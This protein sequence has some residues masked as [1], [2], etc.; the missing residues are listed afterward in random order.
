MTTS[1]P[2]IGLWA[3]SY[4][5]PPPRWNQSQPLGTPVTVTYSFRTSVDAAYDNG[6]YGRPADSF[7]AFPESLRALTRTVLQSI[8]RVAGIHF[9][10]V[11]DGPAAMLQYGGYAVG[12]G[13]GGL[14]NYPFGV[15]AA[16][17]PQGNAGDV[18]IHNVRLN[19]GPDQFVHA[20]LLHETLHSLGLKH[21]FDG[22][23]A[24]QLDSAHQSLRYTVM[25]YSSLFNLTG[26]GSFD[27][28]QF[29][30]NDVPPFDAAALQALYGPSQIRTATGDDVY[31]FDGT[32]VFQ[33]IVDSGGTDT[34]DCSAVAKEVR[35]D[36]HGGATSS[37]GL[38]TENDLA[39]DF[40]ART[41]LTLA[42]A[43]GAIRANA[44]NLNDNRD[45]LSIT[46][47]SLIENAIG[48]A[49]NDMLVGNAADNQLTGNA[50]NDTLN[51]DAGFDT[52]IFRGSRSAYTIV[53]ATDGSFTVTGPDGVDRLTSIEALRFG[54]RTL[55]AVTGG[56]ATIARLYGAAFARAPDAGGLA[57]QLGAVASG[58][59][60]QQIAT[61]FINS[62][63]F[64]ARYGASSSD[65][66]YATALYRN[67][68]GRDPDA[69]GLAVQVDALGHGLSRAQL[70]LNFAD[71]NE[72][73]LRV[74]ADWLIA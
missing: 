72:N 73:R 57:V 36:L 51:G 13:A 25:S 38:W 27:F 47:G 3:G 67:V 68:L 1:D 22:P 41:G 48:G 54:D 19:E 58:V 11:T 43:L 63:E 35:L 70:L 60:T 18:W 32:R 20:M 5:N 55:F 12:N 26:T 39:A 16:G 56:D 29:V 24:V 59:S 64:V 50:G 15:D 46:S 7:T 74:E 4:L 8:E 28:A 69:G 6:V 30:P 14:G 65:T 2:V 61:N 31:R 42:N 21:P 17:R 53:H 62:A 45:T 66:L 52:A 34:I 71:S 10:E 40:A 37:P 49:G 44:S 23:D 9:V 33:A